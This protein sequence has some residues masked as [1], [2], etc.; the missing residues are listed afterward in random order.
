MLTG[1]STGIRCGSV[2][3]QCLNY[4]SGGGIGGVEYDAEIWGYSSHLYAYGNKKY[5]TMPLISVHGGVQTAMFIELGRRNMYLN[6]YAG[7]RYSKPF[8]FKLFSFDN[9]YL[10]LNRVI[11]NLE[12]SPY[13]E[14]TGCGLCSV[15]IY[16]LGTPCENAI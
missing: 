16:F 1:M 13:D 11:H 6:N 7:Y 14:R 12:G 8:D 5:G 10:G 3:I 2:H 4:F 9:I 15:C